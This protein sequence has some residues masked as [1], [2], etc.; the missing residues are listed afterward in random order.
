MSILIIFLSYIAAFFASL[1]SKNKNFIA[2]SSIIG[3]LI[4][5]A[6]SLDIAIRVSQEK[7]LHFNSLFSVGS[8]EALVL[9]IVAFLG[10]CAAIYSRAYINEEVSKGIIGLRRM[11]Q[12]FA[13]FN[14]FILMMAGA[15]LADNPIL[16]WIFIEATTLSTAFLI[17]F[18][19]K[20]SAM[21]A[22]WKYLVINS[23]GL[24]LAFFGTLLYFTAFFEKSAHSVMIS[25]SEL[26]ANAGHI[27]PLV[28]KIAFVFILIG[29][30]TK[31]G[32]VPMHTWKPDAYSKVPTPLAALFSGALLNVVLV[33]IL[34]FKA[35]TDI[36]AGAEFSQNL[37]LI[38]GMLSIVLA[39]LIIFIQKNYKR[40]LAYSSIEHAGI[41][42]L[43][44]GFGGAG[45]YA[46]ILHMIYHSLVKSALFFTAGN[47]FLKYSSTKIAAVKNMVQ[48]IPKTSAAF[49][50][51]VFAVVGLPPFGIFFTKLNILSAGMEKHPFLIILAILSLA[52]AFAGFLKT[53]NSMLFGGHEDTQEEIKESGR[54]TT[55][56]PILLIVILLV[57][58]WWMPAFLRDLINNILLEY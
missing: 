2:W 33:A 32:F 40:L 5:F 1:F 44:F 42:A 10:L 51:G 29:Y 35:I 16:I 43:G 21:E 36:A 54:A 12:Y 28:A 14:L 50:L 56:V 17:S 13:L 3:S 23:V 39:S 8:L 22:A 38:L 37:L 26:L 20:P 41:I 46:A 31:V 48:K 19:N 53:L 57:L 9:L 25:W 4:A 7:M 24:L 11:R 58:S 30:G 49:A 6:A 52:L 15:M 55:C 45:V 18:Y 27:D 34:K 47:I